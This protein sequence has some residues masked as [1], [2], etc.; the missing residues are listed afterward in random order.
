MLGCVIGKTSRMHLASMSQ[1][2]DA[3]R[4][5]AIRRRFWPSVDIRLS[6]IF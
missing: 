1:Q 6:I 3:K 4:G 2:A 5:I